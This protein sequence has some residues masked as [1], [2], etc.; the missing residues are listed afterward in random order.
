RTSWEEEWNA[1]HRGHYD[2]QEQRQVM[3]RDK[4]KEGISSF[5]IGYP[6]LL[7]NLQ[8]MLCAGVSGKVLKLAAEYIGNPAAAG[9]DG[10]SPLRLLKAWRGLSCRDQG[11][12]GMLTEALERAAVHNS[13]NRSGFGR[14]AV[15]VIAMDVSNSMGR[16]V[17]DDESIRRF[18]IGP[19]LAYS[20]KSRGEKIVAGIIG[21]TWRTIAMSQ[22]NAMSPPN[23]MPPSIAAPHPSILASTDQ[24]RR[25]EG[26][27]GFAINAWLVISDLVRKKQVVD[28]VLIFT[29]CPLWNNRAF[30]Q[31]GG[32]DIGRWWRRYRREIAPQATLYLFDLAG[33]GIAPLRKPE[34]GVYLLAGWNERFFDVLDIL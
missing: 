5:R 2:S 33:Y 31:D 13:W 18:D 8:T 24:F 12:A 14:A 3:L 11:G 6:A 30:D 22:P 10:Q 29:D 26:V 17:C 32:A 1:L 19:L 16:P 15:S 23:A 21:N 7:R 4:W 28:K 25:H 9:P 34:E 27:A 20:W